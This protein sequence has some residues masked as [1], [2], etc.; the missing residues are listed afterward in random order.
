V[1]VLP[2][3]LTIVA[4]AFAVGLVAWVLN[5][6]QLYWMAG[7]LILLP[8]VSK[9]IARLEHRGIEVRRVAPAVGHQGETAEVRLHARNLLQLPKLHLSVADELPS[10]LESGGEPIPLHLPPG[11]EDQG[12]YVLR[13]RRR[14][15]Y[16]IPAARV[17]SVD[18]LG[19]YAV[20]S[21]LPVASEV[22]V[23]PRIVDL[24]AWAQPRQRTGG[25][26]T[27]DASMRHG[28]GSSFFGIREYRPGDPLRHVHWRTAARLGRMAVVE[29][30][31][32]E[33][34]NALIAVETARAAEIALD[35]GTTLDLA[36][37][38]AASL[39]AFLLSSGDR[40]RLFAPG[41]TRGVL[42]RDPYPETM[43]G[44][45][46]S[47]ARMQATE[48]EGLPA[49]LGSLASA[50]PAGTLVCWVTTILDG[51]L[52]GAARLLRGA[53][54]QPVIYALSPG[55]R[56]ESSPADTVVD[57]LLSSEIPVVRLYA[58]DELTA[59]ILQ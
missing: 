52:V 57:E 55:R 1:T 27:R 48:R 3:R 6:Q 16:T 15:V 37:G 38:V 17:S 18:P 46:E 8:Q 59:Q 11:G 34:S 42:D 5:A 35:A 30:E 26:G 40:L 13:L 25:Q 14:G 10:G 23:Y 2:T 29:W 49:E 20:E 50:I 32:E 58:D 51:R 44:I 33:S 7:M 19:L 45:L 43:S 54:L 4:A 31:D 12:S 36:A 41:V 53:N 24:P 9:W 22:L 56:G 28:Q 21:R 39:A 47:L